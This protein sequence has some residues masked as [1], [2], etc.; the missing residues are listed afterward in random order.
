MVGD[1]GPV[2]EPAPQYVDAGAYVPETP[3]T[4]P[5]RL[6][7]WLPWLIGALV[8]IVSATFLG[9]I[10]AD[11]IARNIEMNNLISAM[12]DSEAAMAEVQENVE[13]IAS[14]Y[15]DRLPLSTEDQDSLNMALEAAAAQGREQI[16]AAGDEVAAVRWALWHQDVG[17]A[18][19]AYLAHN[20]AWQAYLE[21]AETSGAEFARPQDDVNNTFLDAETAVRRAV[22]VIPLFDL[23]HRVDVIFAPP[24]AD[25]SGSGGSGDGGQA[26]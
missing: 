21:R 5:S 17:R 2:S 23:R 16:A 1:N 24:P 26:A 11:S 10:A 22:P 4:Q 7:R 15:S 3:P 8:F 12:E 6:R 14:A 20:Q 18:Q 9:T 25:P 13:G 19:E